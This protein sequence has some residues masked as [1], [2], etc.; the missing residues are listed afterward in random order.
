M[1]TKLV[2]PQDRMCFSLY[3]GAKAIIARYRPHL[4][5]LDITYP[6]YLVFLILFPINKMAVSELGK[7]LDLDSGTLTPLLKR[8]EQKGVVARIRDEND[9]RRVLIS[10]TESGRMLEDEIVLMQQS[11]QCATG[12]NATEMGE[13]RD[14]IKSLT[15]NLRTTS[16]QC[17]N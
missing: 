17:Q 15:N 5:K 11:V 16:T 9:E 1:K 4:D 10:L 6:Q 13:L 2:M 12:L 3:S 8:M 14:K 7:Q